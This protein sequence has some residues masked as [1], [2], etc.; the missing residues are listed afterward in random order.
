VEE[1]ED[2]FEDAAEAAQSPSPQPVSKGT[3]SKTA[4]AAAAEAAAVRRRPELE[5]EV[6]PDDPL[7]YAV[8]HDTFGDGK[9][10]WALS[11]Q[12][13][14]HVG[15]TP[16]TYK[17]AVESPQA[18]KWKKAMDEEYDSL[19]ANKTWDLEVPPADAHIVGSKW[20]YTQKLGPDGEVVR[21]KARL[22]AKGFS[23]I[24]GRDYDEVFAPVTTHATVRALLAL[25][26]K[27]DM[28]LHQI[29]IK[30]AFLYG[31]LDKDVWMQQPK[32][33]QGGPPGAQC[34]LRKSIYGLKQAPRIWYKK[35]K[36]ELANLGFEPLKADPCMFVAY[37]SDGIVLLTVYVDDILCATPKGDLASQVLVK[38][39]LG[40]EFEMRDLGE[41][42]HFLGMKLTR[43]RKRRYIKAELTA[44][45]RRLIA[46]YGMDS[47]NSVN[48]PADP[49][50]VLRAAA[51]GEELLDVVRYPYAALVGSLLYLSL[52]TRPDIAHAVGMLTRYTAKPTMAHWVAAKRVLRYLH[53]TVDLGITYGAAQQSWGEELFGFCDAD[54]SGDLDSRRSTT[55]FV[56]TFYGGAIAWGSRLQRS[57][58][59]STAEAEYMAAA[60]AT[61]MAAWLKLLFKELG[62]EVAGPLQ[63]VTDNQ[64]CLSILHDHMV[65]PRTKHIDTK[66]H[67]A[68]ESVEAGL[69]AF[70][71]ISSDR[72]VADY[73]TKAVP[74]QKL[75]FCR[76]SLGIQ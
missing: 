21:Y 61:K 55:G 50:V 30:T 64:A 18:E 62:E 70:K 23:Q 73:L 76:Q 25:V 8:G 29:D 42:K 58:A 28:E 6:D 33:Y 66:Y 14:A 36:V 51:D 45:T 56:F 34:H 35:L 43:D 47:A 2:V 11:A 7:H 12:F 68:R 17:Q 60:E 22:V 74:A 38:S 40:E 57:V 52:T 63:M 4:A 27:H 13:S 26:A 41:S 54:W 20:V 72:M 48:T 71:H 1:E 15:L 10:E 39:Q 32:G 59:L 31:D 5:V 49:H 67:F 75:V 19:M 65:N 9:C 24:P 3:R 53:G 16:A 37:C 46:E 44:M 69:V